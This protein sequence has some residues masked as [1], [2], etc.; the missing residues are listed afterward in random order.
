MKSASRGGTMPHL[1]CVPHWDTTSKTFY[2]VRGLRSMLSKCRCGEE[3][4]SREKASVN[5]R[6]GQATH[7]KYT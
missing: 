6:K 3:A 4:A 5:K 2:L 7:A 1:A